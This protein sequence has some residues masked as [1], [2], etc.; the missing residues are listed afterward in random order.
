MDKLNT[1]IL[2]HKRTVII[3]YAVLTVVSIFLA[4][5][6]PVNYNMIDYL[7]E[8]APS[9]KSIDMM[10]KEF[11]EG[12]PNCN[13]YVPNIS[14]IRAR[15]M[16]DELLKMSEVS[17]VVW[18]D[19]LVDITV[20]LEMADSRTVETFYKDGGA[21]YIATVDSE[22]MSEAL[23][24]IR[25]VAGGEA[26]IS[27]QV[28]DL[29][30]AQNATGSEMV[31][32]VALLLP[33]ILIILVFATRS[34]IDPL[35]VLITIG[36]GVLLN[37]GSNI[38][39]KNI[40]FITQA[41][42]A[43]LQMAVSIDYA[44][45]LLH[46]FNQYTDEGMTPFAAMKLAMRTSVVS[47]QASA[48]T[49]LL[50]FLAL[51]F[52]RFRIGPDMGIVLAK[53]IIFSFLTVMTLLPALI[54]ASYRLGDRLRH[55]NLMPSF[56][57]ISKGIIKV[58]WLVIIIVLI[59][60][61]VTYLGQLNNDFIYGINDE[62]DPAS[63]Y[64]FD[65][66][67][68]RDKFG[69]EQQWALL[70]PRGQPGSERV[71][72]D[73]LDKLPGITSVTGYARLPGSALPQEFVPADQV[74]QLLS[75]NY[76]RI[77]I[78]AA[79][80]AESERSFELVET[81]RERAEALY[82]EGVHLAGESVSLVDMRDTIHKDNSIVNG[83]AIL[84][85]GLVILLTFRS[86]SI[87]LVLL[88]TIET[89]IWFN[90]SIPYFFGTKLSYLGYLIISTVQLGAT[91]DYAIL[92]TQLYLE[93]RQL[94]TPR[95]AAKDALTNTLPAILPPAMI[96][97]LTG[98]MLSWIS[99]LSMV[100]EL[101]LVLGRG[102]MLSFLM[103]VLFLPALIMILDKPIKALTLKSGWNRGANVTEESVVSTAELN[104]P[105]DKPSNESSNE[106]NEPNEPLQ[107]Y[108][109]GNR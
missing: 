60:I 97:M 76:S 14:L 9:T 18:L 57:G 74:E 5:A 29:A 35:L 102:A 103:V 68:I 8:E 37:M 69:E 28:I 20:P 26:A 105:I 64:A 90:L 79:V 62:F 58:R 72:M 12:L 67:L 101:G 71:L 46:R 47:I 53:G 19:M 78:T 6:V 63:R 70:V 65:R 45:F 55:R 66:Q 54:L 27:G 41:V 48:M 83:L 25:T 43:V 99:T 91:V 85:V 22:N 2:N 52:M 33:L 56:A 86:L 96:L 93:E 88:L 108:V 23:E 15:E 31:K 24:N 17:G 109:N 38:I 98:Y 81:V 104:K 100:N 59:F 95:Q 87:P 40:S 32:V 16:K 82:P 49:T 77:I 1:S 21:R 34:W 10:Q 30:F 36:V 84:A 80:P 3:V 44:V 50:G 11:D 61:P 4:M 51:I 75:P 89:A 42:G 39:F 92:Y 106:P 7:P 107:K 94:K 13:I 73:Q